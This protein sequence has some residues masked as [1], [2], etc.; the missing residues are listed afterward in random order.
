MHPDVEEAIDLVDA[1]VFS[2]D[3]LSD[4][5]E[6]KKF[7]DMLQRWQRGVAEWDEED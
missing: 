3:T 5:E 4:K 2:G 7:S 1:M 6:R